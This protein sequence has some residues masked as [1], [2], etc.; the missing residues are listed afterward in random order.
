[1]KRSDSESTGEPEE[2]TLIRILEVLIAAA[3]LAVVLISPTQYGIRV[4]GKV[5]LSPADPL[6]WVTF[7]LWLALLVGRRRFPRLGLAP[8]LFVVFAA[9]CAASISRAADRFSAMKDLFQ[10]VEYFLVA[11]GLFVWNMTDPTA[12]KRLVA[13]FLAS[14]VV[15]TIVGAWHYLLA[16]EPALLVR[17]T[18][19]NRNVLGGYLALV[20]PFCFGLALFDSSW[21]RRVACVCV[22]IA[23]MC[24]NL[25]G[26]SV[27]A[28]V[29]SLIVIAALRGRLAFLFTAVALLVGV[30]VVGPLLP[31]ENMESLYESVR[32]HDDEN[33]VARRYTEWQAATIMVW[34]NPVLGVGAGNYQD[35]IGSYYGVLPDPTGPS[36]PD[37][38]NLYL[39]LAGTTG[40][41]GLVAYLGMLAWSM[42]QACSRYF[43][44][45][46]RFDRGVAVGAFG[47]VLAFA[48]AG[49]WSP[50][51]VRGIGLPL[52][53]VLALCTWR[54]RGWE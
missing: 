25:S 14:A 36:E 17:G 33:Q 31:R 2:M 52:V 6:V 28:I 45:S 8:L 22:V 3:T 48:I 26:G 53:F 5:Y 24:I 18:F 20:L 32:L 27:I 49:L 47:G 40:L 43:E 37:T 16:E 44:A 13:A 23:G 51:L 9:T 39:V 19:G 29:V 1:M 21:W 38:Q 41:C 4:L 10:I 30:L 35:N 42:A 15:V 34:E 11:Y 54:A 7:L 12:R 46:D 50:L